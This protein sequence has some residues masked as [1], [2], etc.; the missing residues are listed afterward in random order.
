MYLFT[1]EI[2]KQRKYSTFIPKQRKKS[3]KD[4]P[5]GR[6]VTANKTKQQIVLVFVSISSTSECGAEMLRFENTPANPRRFYTHFFSLLFFLWQLCLLCIHRK[7]LIKNNMISSADWWR[8]NER[9]SPQKKL[10]LRFIVHARC[11]VTIF[12]RL[13]IGESVTTIDNL[14]DTILMLLIITLST[15]YV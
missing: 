6:T 14:G 10:Q 7:C 1:T 9:D 4:S 2:P 12:K 3:H 15:I 11:T 5:I 13:S 8:V